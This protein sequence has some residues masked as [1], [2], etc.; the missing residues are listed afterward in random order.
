MRHSPK[1]PLPTK[2]LPASLTG[3]RILE[4]LFGKSRRKDKIIDGQYNSD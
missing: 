4:A 3:Q 2:K 1:A